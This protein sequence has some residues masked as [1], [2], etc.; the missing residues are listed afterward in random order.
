MNAKDMSA[1]G[2]DAPFALSPLQQR[3]WFLEKLDTAQSGSN[4]IAVYEVTGAIDPDQLQQALDRLVAGAGGLRRVFV[5]NESAVTQRVLPAMQGYGLDLSEADAGDSADVVARRLVAEA[6]ATPFDLSTGPLF[7]VQL[8]TVAPDAH[9]LLIAGHRLLLDLASLDRMAQALLAPRAS[10]IPEALAPQLGGGGPAGANGMGPLLARL[11]DASLVCELPL[12]FPRPGMQSTRTRYYQAPLS[13]AAQGALSALAGRH[14]VA[15]HSVALSA[16]FALIYRYTAQSDILIGCPHR[17]PAAAL[18]VCQNTVVIRQEVDKQMPV[19]TLIERVAGA[20]QP[21]LDADRHPPFA[22]LIDAI[23]PE[24]DLSRSPIVQHGFAFFPAAFDG[25]D[26]IRARRVYQSA[27]LMQMDLML[28]CDAAGDGVDLT[29][30]YDAAL[31]EPATVARFHR[32]YDRMLVAMAADDTLPVGRMAL[33]SPEELH[34]ITVAWNQTDREVEDFDFVYRLFEKQAA[35]TPDA[36]AVR[37]PGRHLTYR[38]LNRQANQLA[39]LLVDRGVGAD[40]IVALLEDRCI[41]YLVTMLAI[42]K[43]GGAFLPLSS[44]YPQKRITRI[45]EKSDALL[46]IAGDEYVGLLQAAVDDMPAEGKSRLV[47]LSDALEESQRLPGDNLPARC[48]FGHLAY[49]MFTSGSTGEPKGVMVE[50]AGMVNHNYAKIYDLGM[51]ADDVLAQTGRQTFDIMVWQFVSP[52]IVGATVYV[53]PD[54]IA[55]DAFR[56]L[57]EADRCGITMLQLVPVNIEVVLD[58][59]LVQGEDRPRLEKLRWMIPTGDALYTDLCRRWLSTYPHTQMLNTYG[60]TECSDDQCHHVISVPPAETYR[61]PIMTVGRPIINTQVYIVDE[62]MQ[63]VPVGVVGELYI[64]GIGVGRGYLKE[65]DRTAATFVPDPFSDSPDARL[66]KSGDQARYLPDG[67]IEFLGRIGHMLKIRGFRIEPGEIQSVLNRHTTVAQSTV[68]AHNFDE[69]GTQLVAYVVPRP[70]RAFDAEALRDHVRQH[71]PD[72]MVPPFIVALDEM[73]LNT[74]GKVDRKA[75]PIPVVSQAQREIVEPATP[76]E[77]TLVEMWKSLLKLEAV[78]VTD[79]FFEVGGHSLLALQLFARIYARFH[80]KLPLTVI[81]RSPTLRELAAVIDGGYVAPSDLR[82]VV[83]IHS[84]DGSRPPL[85][86]IHAHGGHVGRFFSLAKFIGEDQPVYGIQALGV[87]GDYEQPDNFEEIA[88]AY[89][90]EMKTVQPTGPYYFVGDCMGGTIGFE[91]TRQ[92]EEAGDEVDLLVMVEAFRTGEVDLKPGVP[93]WAYEVVYAVRIFF[94]YLQELVQVPAAEKLS[95]MRVLIQKVVQ[96]FRRNVL[97]RFVGKVPIADPLLETQAALTVAEQTYQP[98]P[99]KT[100]LTQFNG[101]LTWGAQDA[102]GTL[103]WQGYS[104]GGIQVHEFDAM[105]GTLLLDEGPITASMAQK[106][107]ELIDERLAQRRD[108]EGGQP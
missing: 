104:A 43:A 30:H 87:D 72:Y 13:A 61:P 18:D 40:T 88:R 101:K 71:L 77:R 23:K 20:Y 56:L 49:V 32:H 44:M 75:L 38:E 78:S 45:L 39:H 25:E 28:T 54:D 12:D 4:V 89:I 62:W 98:A 17:P 95:H 24:R 9:L 84:G 37:E 80:Q 79:N 65:P 76:T 108:G 90:A 91:M 58:V 86:C 3:L 93:R 100:P 41:N 107:R 52:L 82:C 63:P 97:S 66:Y 94:Y 73:P 48:A 105:R 22:D 70:G 68:T 74:N 42:N 10:S 31:F 46:A 50:H 36:I 60:A 55:L 5:E 85:F 53:M 15:P 35:R 6:E 67:T 33:T 96:N 92:L 99:I 51:T 64:G 19:A 1:S 83:P 103:G 106:V 26:A 29:W 8:H 59:A 21:A 47:R 27:P 14:G 57:E 2:G 69:I 16:Y 34:E 7:R 11:E 102:D 81:F